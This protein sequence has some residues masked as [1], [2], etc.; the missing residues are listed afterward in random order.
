MSHKPRYGGLPTLLDTWQEFAKTPDQ[1]AREAFERDPT[2]NWVGHVPSY[3]R[4]QPQQVVVPPVPRKKQ[5]AAGGRTPTGGKKIISGLKPS[6]CCASWYGKPYAHDG[7]QHVCNRKPGHAGP[8]TCVRCQAAN[9]FQFYE[10]DWG[11]HEKPGTPTTAAEYE[12]QITH[13]YHVSERVLKL[14]HMLAFR[15]GNGRQE[16]L[17]LQKRG[18]TPAEISN[19]STFA[20]QRRLAGAMVCALIGLDVLVFKEEL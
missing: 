8:H 3:F 2:C 4:P 18:I 7:S 17:G 9:I 10:A 15:R 5:S 20:Y 6:R 16:Y 11:G 19:Y 12:A 14:F 1:R 13:T